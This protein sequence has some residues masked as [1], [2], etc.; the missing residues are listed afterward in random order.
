LGTGLAFVAAFVKTP[1]FPPNLIIQWI[2][3]GRIGAAHHW[4]WSQGNLTCYNSKLETVKTIST[5]RK[6]IAILLNIMLDQS[7]LVVCGYILATTWK[8][9]T[10]TNLV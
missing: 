5:P 8:N 1:A 4:W 7:K 9:F 6:I 2:E 3:V 10:E